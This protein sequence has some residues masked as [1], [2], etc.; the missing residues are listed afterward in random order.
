MS[1]K[2]SSVFQSLCDM[3]SSLMLLDDIDNLCCNDI[4]NT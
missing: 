2:N 3:E 1:S 4:N